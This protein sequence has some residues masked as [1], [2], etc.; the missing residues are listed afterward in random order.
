MC[1]CAC[2]NAETGQAL[3]VEVVAVGVTV[4]S[5][6]GG[7]E[8]WLLVV[9]LAVCVCARTGRLWCACDNLY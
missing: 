1:V 7:D 8:L 2:L 3:L 6:E 5:G 4:V 9:T